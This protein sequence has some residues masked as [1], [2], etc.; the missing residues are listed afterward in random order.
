MGMNCSDFDTLMLYLD[1]ELP[2]ERIEEISVHL[3]TCV[4]CR[5]LIDSQRRL[6][7][8]W[9]ESFISPE[10]EKFRNLEQ[11][12]FNRIN[13]RWHWKALIPA[14]AGIIAVLLGVKLILTEQPS[15]DSVA[16][17]TRSSRAE[18][19]NESA[20][21]ITEDIDVPASLE[22]GDGTVFPGE[23]ASAAPENI[24]SHSDGAGETDGDIQDDLSSYTAPVLQELSPVEE[25]PD[26]TV[27]RGADEVIP[28][29]VNSDFEIGVASGSGVTGLPGLSGGCCA[30]EE[31]AEELR[32]SLGNV[33]ADAG[34]DSGEAETA[35]LMTDVFFSTDADGN[36]NVACGAT[37]EVSSSGFEALDYR[38]VE[39]QSECSYGF[40][41]VP[42]HEMDSLSAKTCVVLTF[43]SGGLPDS[44]TASLLDSLFACWNDYIPFEYR[45]TVLVIP[46]AEVQDLLLEGNSVPAETIE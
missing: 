38:S 7:T 17:R 21:T 43:D 39:Q 5:E 34:E 26:E 32:A 19:L 8:S 46:L 18:L 31:E 24:Q 30:E 25:S 13:R 2:D 4:R 33:A 20:D 45:D 22:E 44:T 15:L 1:G 9:R 12:I 29:T 23:T 3:A 6:E 28:E 27:S 36:E 37:S 42:S 40:D 16:E 11:S 10:T 14:A 41:D 35:E